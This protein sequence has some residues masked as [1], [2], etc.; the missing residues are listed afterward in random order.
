MKLIEKQKSFDE[1][2]HNVP[3]GNRIFRR[4]ARFL[5]VERNSISCYS[6]IKFDILKK[7]CVP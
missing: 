6:K 3:S 4:N 2:I 7:K 1:K 5:I